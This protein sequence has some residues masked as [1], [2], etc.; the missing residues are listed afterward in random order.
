MHNFRNVTITG[1][2]IIQSVC[3]F[4]L[5]KQIG[6]ASPLINVRCLSFDLNVNNVSRNLIDKNFCAAFPKY[7]NVSK[8]CIHIH[9]ST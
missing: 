1:L 8:T 2:T 7:I 3:S 9:D 6:F 5:D 4:C